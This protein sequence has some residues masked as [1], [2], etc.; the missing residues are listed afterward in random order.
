MKSNSDGKLSQHVLFSRAVH[1]YCLVL[2]KY[3]CMRWFVVGT[4]I[5]NGEFMFTEITDPRG[6]SGPRHK[7]QV[8]RFPVVIA[9]KLPAVYLNWCGRR[10]VGNIPRGG[11]P[12]CRSPLDTPGYW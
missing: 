6:V 3:L 10:S 1:G 4:V 12:G 9:Y 8:M 7:N 11:R 2:T 5:V